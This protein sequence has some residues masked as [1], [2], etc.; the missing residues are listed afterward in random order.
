VDD[1]YELDLLKA[2]ENEVKKRPRAKAV[3]LEVEKDCPGDILQLV[4][5][6]INFKKEEA[7]AI[8][9]DLDL[10][11]LFIVSFTIQ[12]FWTFE[13]MASR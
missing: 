9:V 7:A 13:Q 8:K 6:G 2:I 10:T 4:C 3:Y 1:E 11:Y 5:E 12:I